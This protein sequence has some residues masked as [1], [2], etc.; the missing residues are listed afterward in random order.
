MHNHHAN[1]KILFSGKVFLVALKYSADQKFGDD[2]LFAYKIPFFGLNF[3]ISL[4][5]RSNQNFDGQSARAH[6]FQFIDA[7]RV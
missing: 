3:K 4:S 7:R 6:E 5:N 2:G 1:T